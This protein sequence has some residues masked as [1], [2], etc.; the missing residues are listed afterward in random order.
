[1]LSTAERWRKEVP[2]DFEFTVKAFQGIT[3]PITSP[4]WRKAGKQRPIKNV[5]NYGHLKPTNENFECWDKTIEVCKVLKARAVIIQL[6]PSFEAKDDAL[7]DAINFLSSIKKPKL[8]C[9]ELRHKSWFDNLTKTKKLFEKANSIHITDPL[10]MKPLTIGDVSYSRL[11]G[12][13]KR[14]YSY[15]YSDEELMKIKDKL[16]DWG[17][18]ESYVLFNN[19]Y[20]KDD[21]S[22]F[23]TLVR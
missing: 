10:T 2:E 5:E 13:G 7:N 8:L 6:P 19:I 22:R 9:I 11:H 15:K 1:M 17:Y 18:K 4:T 20:M 21:A 12:L 16:E 3:H 14:P 23:L